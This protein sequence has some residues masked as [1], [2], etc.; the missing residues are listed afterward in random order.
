MSP[1]EFG[2]I[3]TA[4]VLIAITNLFILNTLKELLKEHLN[5]QLWTE[6]DSIY[7]CYN[8]HTA[9]KFDGETI[10]EDS[11]SMASM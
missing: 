9:I 7:E 5:V 8:V 2:A 6:Y 11:F 4:L 1:L 3:I 10:S